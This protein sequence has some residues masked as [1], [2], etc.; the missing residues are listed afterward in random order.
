MWESA[1]PEG[2]V[3]FSQHEQ[4]F[5]QSLQKDKEPEFSGQELQNHCF[6][7]L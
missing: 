3:E 7:L 1:S 4:R 5:L 6:P 2:V